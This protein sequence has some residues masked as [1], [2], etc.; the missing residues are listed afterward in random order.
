M[1]TP[2]NR[3]MEAFDSVASISADVGAALALRIMDVGLVSDAKIIARS[4]QIDGNTYISTQNV[5]FVEKEGLSFLGNAQTDL[6]VCEGSITKEMRF[7]DNTLVVYDAVGVEGIDRCWIMSQ[8]RWMQYEQTPWSVKRIIGMNQSHCLPY[9]QATVS[10]SYNGLY[11]RQ[12]RFK[13][14]WGS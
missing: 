6:G 14:V 1:V 2:H 12:N 7:L 5:M 9:I 10:R 3:P 8:T 4:V 13:L 11:T